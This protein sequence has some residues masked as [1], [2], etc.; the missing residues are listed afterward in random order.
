MARLT[1]FE[2][3]TGVQG[4]KGDPGYAGDPGVKGQKGSPGNPG[5]EGPRGNHSHLFFIFGAKT[6][7]LQGGSSDAEGLAAFF[8]SRALTRISA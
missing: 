4:T 2:G 3:I 6:C 5:Q 8:A 7:H 1:V